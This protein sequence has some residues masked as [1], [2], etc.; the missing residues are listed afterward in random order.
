MSSLTLAGVLVVALVF[1]GVFV[2]MAAKK[3]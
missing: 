2:A 1:I 3:K